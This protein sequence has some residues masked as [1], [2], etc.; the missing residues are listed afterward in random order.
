MFGSMLREMV[1]GELRSRKIAGEKRS[2][3]GM[4]LDDEPI[5]ADGSGPKPLHG[6]SSEMIVRDRI[7]E[8]S[9]RVPP[10]RERI[11]HDLATEHSVREICSSNEHAMQHLPIPHL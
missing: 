3:F 2:L 9:V 7:C 11:V 8:P 1:S 5:G 4:R 10:V 6:V